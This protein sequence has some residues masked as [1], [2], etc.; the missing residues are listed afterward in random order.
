M[1]LVMTSPPSPVR[2][3]TSATHRLGRPPHRAAIA[4]VALALAA[5]IGGGV[6]PAVASGGLFCN[7]EDGSL[8]FSVQAGLTRGN[9]AFFNFRG[10]LHARQPDVP[11][12]LRDLKLASRDLIQHWLDE[13]EAKL[14][15][16]RERTAAPYGSVSLRVETRHA[17]TDEEGSYEGSY[18]LT[19]SY[20]EGKPGSEAKVVEAHGK[21]TCSAE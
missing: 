17:D 3:V 6:A 8:T 5:A 12:E 1:K 16:Y 4:M 7:A 19:V 10:E 20:V 18:V 21:A 15:I 11:K 13:R 14:L 9:G 2:A